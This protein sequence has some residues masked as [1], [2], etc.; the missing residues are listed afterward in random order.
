MNM[1]E[2]IFFFFSCLL[3]VLCGWWFGC[4]IGG[5]AWIVGIVLGILLIGGMRIV[6]DLFYKWRPMRPNC[7]LGKCMVDDYDYIKRTNEGV[8]FT[9]KCGG[10]Y[11][12]TNG[13]FKEVLPGGTTV[14]YM[15][16]NKL[17]RWIRDVVPPAN[18]LPSE[19]GG[20][21]RP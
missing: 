1:F 7:R 14:A 19:S 13:H 6:L 10:T 4:Y 17:G 8:F 9:C 18:S 16:R 5:W 21:G 12:L 3:G 2:K 20:T 15:K 11:L